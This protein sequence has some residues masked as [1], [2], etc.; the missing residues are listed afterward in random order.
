[1]KKFLIVLFIFLLTIP[2]QAQTFGPEWVKIDENNYLAAD[3]VVGAEDKYGFTFLLKSYN[4]GQYEPF[5]GKSISYALGHYEINCAE[6]SYKIGLLD[7]YDRNDGFVI[8]DYNR[9]STFQPLVQGSAV[10]LVSQKL[11]K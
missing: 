2:V 5:N 8:G 1:M 11:C 9:Y 7:S 6:Q 4:K 3:S 10:G